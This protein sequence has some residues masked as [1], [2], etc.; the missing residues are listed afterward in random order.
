MT[1][2]A[3]S[4]G[5]SNE[6]PYEGSLEEVFDNPPTQ[7]EIEENSRPIEEIAEEEAPVNAGTITYGIDSLARIEITKLALLAQNILARQENAP[8]TTT[9]SLNILGFDFN[10]RVLPKQDAMIGGENKIGRPGLVLEV[11][12]GDRTYAVAKLEWDHNK[13][14]YVL[15]AGKGVN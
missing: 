3:Q 8:S 12:D 4:T 1:K 10:V 9:G 2:Q 14:V 5:A 6:A 15:F 11:N 7:E 13:Q